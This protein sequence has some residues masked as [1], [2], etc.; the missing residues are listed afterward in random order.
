MRRTSNIEHR[1]SKFR[2]LFVRCWALTVRCSTFVFGTHRAGGGVVAAGLG[3]SPV[4][5]RGLWG[6]GARSTLE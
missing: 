5:L 4:A 2:D 6:T 3:T 1:T